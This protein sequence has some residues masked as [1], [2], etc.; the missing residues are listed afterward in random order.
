M[1][2]SNSGGFVFP[3]VKTL[4][5]IEYGQEENIVFFPKIA[6]SGAYRNNNQQSQPE[7]HILRPSGWL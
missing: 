2:Y 1:L 5:R 6:I 7:G 4:K 3:L